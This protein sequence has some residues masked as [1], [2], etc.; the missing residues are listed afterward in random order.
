MNLKHANIAP[1]LGF[2]FEPDLCLISPWYA[3]GNI[4]QHLRNNPQVDRVKLA[5]EVTDGLVY[6][7]G[8]SPD[9]IIHGDLKPDN[10][11]INDDGCAVIIDFGLSQVADT[12]S[13]LVPTDRGAGHVRWLAPEILHDKPKSLSS[14]VYSFGCLALNIMTSEQPFRHI[15][16]SS[17]AALC[18]ALANLNK[19]VANRKDYSLLDHA[20]PFWD[21]LDK[22]WDPVPGARPTMPD[23]KAD[24]TR[25]RG[26]RSD[27]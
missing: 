18:L 20:N 11:L 6:L 26:A 22:C 23:V 25:I 3:R 27:K 4:L 12:L 8:C 19:P 24:I 7:H 17:R 9:P 13:S 5:D 10:V 21:I 1:L 14:D 15:A 16:S 2:S